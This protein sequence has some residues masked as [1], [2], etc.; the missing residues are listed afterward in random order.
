MKKETKTI[1]RKTLL[2]ARRWYIIDANNRTVGRLASAIAGLL[3]GKHNPSFSPHLDCGD[4]VLV[5][6]ARNLHLS[7]NKLREKIYYRHT[8]YPGGIRR[9]SASQMIESHPEKILR[10]AVEGMLPK[11]RLGRQ[12]AAKLKIYAGAEHPHKAQQPERVLLG[13]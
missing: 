9:I 6:N 13:A 2:D 4:F 11:N 10:F 3:R 7:G 12:M 5:V 8:E 1:S